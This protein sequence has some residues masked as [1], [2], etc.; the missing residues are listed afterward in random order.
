MGMIWHDRAADQFYIANFGNL[1]P[2]LLQF[3]SQQFI[4]QP[5]HSPFGADGHEITRISSRP[6]AGVHPMGM[7]D[8]LI[9]QTKFKPTTDSSQPRRTGASDAST[10]GGAVGLMDLQRSAGCRGV[11]CDGPSGCFQ[12]TVLIFNAVL[13]S[14]VKVLSS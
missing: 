12:Q 9:H 14:Y 2:R 10:A 8:C 6:P 11:A 1:V 5:G 3:R 4:F 13:N 7:P